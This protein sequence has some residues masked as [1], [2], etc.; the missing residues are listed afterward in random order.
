MA[1]NPVDSLQ[2]AQAGIRR[3]VLDNGLVV[4]LKQDRS[5]PLVAIQ[6]WVNAGAIHEGAQLGGGLSHYLEH[7]VFKGTARRKPHQQEG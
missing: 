6:Y 4:L 2:A 3:V 1:Q 5:A 7:M